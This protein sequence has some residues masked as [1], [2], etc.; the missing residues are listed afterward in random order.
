MATA[1]AK[2][3]KK[4]GKSTRRASASRGPASSA[5]SREGSAGGSRA[6]AL[7]DL[8]GKVAAID[9]TQAVIEFDLDGNVLTANAN[10]LATLGYELAEIQGKHHRMFC[11]PA[12]VA[13]P[14]Y[15][16]FWQKLGRGENDVGVYRRIGKNGKEIWIHASYN[17]ILDVDGKPYKVVKFAS[18]IT[19]QQKFEAEA[20]RTQNMVDSAPTNIVLC[21]RD[22]KIVYLNPASKQV[23]R[24][25][26]QYLPV[27]VEEM[28]GQSVDIFHKNPDY[29]R[30]ILSDPKNLPH[31][32][33]IQ[34]GP[35]KLSLLVS[36]IK[37]ADGTYVGPMLTWEVVT[38]Q[39]RLEADAARASSMIENVP[40]NMMFADRNLNLLYMN[41]ASKKTMRTLEQYLPCKV[42]DMIGRSIDIFHK[43]PEHQR[44]I[45]SDPK[46]LPHRA[47]IQ[48]GPEKLDL[49]VSAIYDNRGEYVGPM[50]T[51]EVVTE[52]R[53]ADSAVKHLIEAATL[54]QLDERADVSSLTGSY[55]DLVGGVNQMLDGIVLPLKQGIGVLDALASGDLTQRVVGDYQ[56]E[57]DRMKNSINNSIGNLAQM[58]EQIRLASDTIGQGSEEI[59][60]GN[61]DLSQRM[62]EQ[63]SSLEETA[64]SMEEMSGT[65]QQ[66]A[67]NAKQANQLAIQC[68]GIAEKG[69][70]V[71]A[72]AV[73]SMGEINDSSRKI[74]DI[75]G[76]I[77]E[78]A[79]QTNLLALNAAVEAARAGEQGRGFAV[80]AAEVRNLAQRSATAAKEIKTLIQ[81]SAHKVQEGSSLVN[82]SG[83]TLEEVVA[84]V[85]RVADIIGEISAASQ[86]Q[87]SGVE[88]V[89]KAVTQ[90]DQ[91]TQQNAAL[92]E[93]TAA[94]S[95]AMTEQAQSLRVQVGRLQLDSESER[96]LGEK[97]VG[98]ARASSHGKRAG[99]SGNGSLRSS[100]GG[101]AP[102]T[103]DSFEEF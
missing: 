46:N 101:S 9:K 56:G 41:P 3:G 33:D 43:N 2:A 58:V 54:G 62:E 10:F 24:S 22:L 90:L 100:G 68:R 91:I 57:L 27:K 97:L 59:S 87:A 65:I 71:V 26:E 72:R 4:S 49:L 77:D 44:R 55:R 64:A 69:G 67:D 99:G 17:P 7:K 12:Y 38:E 76:V 11:D 102:A 25:L 82:E 74:A 18:D 96:R 88:Q 48:V 50:V 28:I 75:I 70:A 32:A 14:E 23:L 5:V 92:V 61:H 89:N 20:T 85:K 93:E 63:A 36:A 15:A 42:D 21:D 40:I 31:R 66:N 30:R 98:M 78:I 19:R 45:L 1:H 29:Q 16:A 35:E 95:Q 81:D 13:T 37:D 53:T 86:E 83:S 52:Q 60:K 6:T 51:W 8:E 103:A 79:F 34:V 73:S 39:R 47:D 94:A 84:S 80:V